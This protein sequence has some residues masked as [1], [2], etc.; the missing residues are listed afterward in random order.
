MGHGIRT[1]DLWSVTDRR[2]DRRTLINCMDLANYV[3]V[4]DN[5]IQIFHLRKKKSTALS[6]H[7]AV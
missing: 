7:L 5:R 1:N 4:R 3:E 6:L 2:T